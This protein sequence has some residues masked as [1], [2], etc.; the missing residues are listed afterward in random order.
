MLYGIYL[1]IA[2]ALMVSILYQ[3]K[4]YER[5]KGWVIRSVLGSLLWLPIIILCIRQTLT[6]PLEDDSHDQ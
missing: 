5:R 4:N 6:L 2:I 3:A 1:G